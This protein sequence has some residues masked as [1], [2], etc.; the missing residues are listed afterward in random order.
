MAEQDRRGGPDE[1][2]AVPPRARGATTDSQLTVE[3]LLAR[4][5]EAAVAGTGGRRRADRRASSPAPPSRPASSAPRP[6]TTTPPPPPRPSSPPPVRATPVARAAAPARPAPSPGPAS[7]PTPPVPPSSA[8]PDP[9][10]GPASAPTPPV[11]APAARPAPSSGPSSAPPPPVPPPVSAAPGTSELPA[12][13]IV[14][15]PAPSPG[16]SALPAQTAGPRPTLPPVP[17]AE[18]APPVRASAP[19]TRQ[20]A[21]VPPL[22]GTERGRRPSAPVPPL[23]GTERAR[24]SAPVPPLPGLRPAAPLPPIPGRDV[25]VPEVP[26]TRAERLAARSPLH[27]RLV[28][29]A[30]VVSVLVA[31][32]GGFYVGLYVYADRSV[33]RVA[34]LSTTAPEILAPQLQDGATTWLVLG[35]GAPGEQGAAA[36]SASLLRLT[37]DGDRALVLDVPS[38][39]LVDTPLC[40]TPDGEVRQ[41][42]TEPLAQALAAGP[43]CLVRAVQQLSGLRVDHYLD[44]DLGRAGG[45]V[46]ASCP[47]DALP[48]ATVAT[49]LNPVR[50]VSLATGAADV[51]TTDEET[52]LA[53]LRGL[54]DTL[55][56]LPAGAVE[57]SSLPVA[58][59]GYLPVG[60]TTAAVVLDGTATRELFDS[61]ISTGELPPPVPADPAT[62]AAGEDVSVTVPP[63][64]VTVS[65]LDATGDTTDPATGA[66][67]DTAA[68]LAAQGF[69]PGAVGIEPA[70]VPTSLVRYAPDAVEQARTVAAAVPGAVL[71]PVAAPGSGVQLVV[72]SPDLPVS[73]VAVGAAVPDTALPARAPTATCG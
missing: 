64:G 21:P 11:T 39:A 6:N 16:T 2:P 70:A 72:A 55:R 9:S 71:E 48:V 44:V 50:A 5:R 40:R 57:R 37:G 7:A 62:P 65:V 52:S 17:A 20:S 53:D 14:V 58:R 38:T 32:V 56:A 34:A 60:S 66:G 51:A 35:T 69:V 25:P 59:P 49:L 42:V 45:G 18:D 47:T 43:G 19:V 22:P 8:R 61:V 3:A 23:P 12:S 41:P 29:V 46:P 33:D 63:S 13:G 28:R 26:R 24:T 73:P 30:V 67:A 68:A 36:V 4:S 27:R 54:A 10:P 31:L 15:A 1:A